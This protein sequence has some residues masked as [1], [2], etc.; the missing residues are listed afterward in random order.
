ML[1]A[2]L[3]VTAVTHSAT[4][5]P[6][7]VNYE[8]W[9]YSTNRTD[10]QVRAAITAALGRLVAAQPIGGNVVGSDPGKIFAAALRS[11]IIGALPEIFNAAVSLPAG[12]TTLNIYDVAILGTVTCTALHLTPTPDGNVIAA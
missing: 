6:L 2:P 5:V 10:D 8:V 3:A 9:L 4:V 11:A 12:D 1:A 7:L